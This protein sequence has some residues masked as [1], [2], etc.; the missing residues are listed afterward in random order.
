MH[1]LFHHAQAH[2]GFCYR[3]ESQGSMSHDTHRQSRRSGWGTYRGY[4]ARQQ[5]EQAER[6]DDALGSLRRRMGRRDADANEV[7]ECVISY[8]S[9]PGPLEIKAAVLR[10]VCYAWCTMRRFQRSLGG[11]HFRDLCRGGRSGA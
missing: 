10:T 2:A 1:V 5:G 3:L 9:R 4:Y 11:C 7:V 6:R 8:L